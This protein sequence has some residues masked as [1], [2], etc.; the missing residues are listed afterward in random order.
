VS[1]SLAST[2]IRIVRDPGK[3]DWLKRKAERRAKDQRAFKRAARAL[4]SW[5]RSR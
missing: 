1:R 3:V 5:G 4:V 2:R